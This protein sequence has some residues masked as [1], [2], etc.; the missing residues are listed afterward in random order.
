MLVRHTICLVALALTG[1]S[2][3]YAGPAGAL[4]TVNTLD[5]SISFSGATAATL[6]YLSDNDISVP[7]PSTCAVFCGMGVLG[8][9]IYRRRRSA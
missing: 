6:P 9:A 1:A 2:T 5:K 4:I 8:L 3:L 7:E